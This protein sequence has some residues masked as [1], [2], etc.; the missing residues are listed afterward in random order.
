MRA[1]GIR[2]L[3][4]KGFENIWKNRMMAFASFCVLLISLLLVGLSVLVSI[5]ISSMI[6]GM[7]DKNEIIIYLQDDAT[8]MEISELY[9]ELCR[10]ENIATMCV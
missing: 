3:L 7:E 6:G 8:D 2:Y 1:S 4:G 5:N 9:G 10:M